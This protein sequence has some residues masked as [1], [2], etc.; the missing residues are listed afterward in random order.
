MTIRRVSGPHPTRVV[1]DVRLRVPGDAG[2]FTDGQAPT[3]L[4]CDARD[5]ARAADRVGAHQ[6]LAV[7]SLVDAAG[8]VVWPALLVA[9]R[10]RGLATVPV[11]GE[12][13]TVSR[14]LAQGV[15]DRLHLMVAPV[16]I[17]QGK[18]GVRLPPVQHMNQCLRPRAAA[19]RAAWSQGSRKS[20]Q[21]AAKPCRSLMGARLLR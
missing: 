3:L 9:L 18:P 19:A 2:V 14:C 16:L 12:G 1:L 7:P 13:V 15:L 21:P 20:S 6:V 11:E 8:E 10:E 4:V 5:R 17:G